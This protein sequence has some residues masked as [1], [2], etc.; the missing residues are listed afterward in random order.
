MLNI[1]APGFVLRRSLDIGTPLLVTK[2]L[3]WLVLL[4]R[5]LVLPLGGK[6]HLGL[7]RLAEAHCCGQ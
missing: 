1:L 3:L 4:P 6:H 5:W 2:G 7:S